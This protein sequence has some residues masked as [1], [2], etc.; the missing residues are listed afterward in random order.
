LLGADDFAQGGATLL[1]PQL[2][3]DVVEFP[4]LAQDPGDGNGIKLPGFKKF[5]PCVSLMWSST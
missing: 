2:S 5:A 1:L 3:F 4:D